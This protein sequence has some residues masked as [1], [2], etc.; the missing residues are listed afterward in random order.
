MAGGAGAGAAAIGL[1]AGD[2]VVAG[3]F[4]DGQAVGNVNGV[5]GAVMLDIGDLGHM[6]LSS[7]QLESRR[8]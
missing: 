8:A 4:H 7:P 3:A 6:P 1:D 5:L 2:V